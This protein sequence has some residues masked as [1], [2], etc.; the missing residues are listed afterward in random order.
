MLDK[1]FELD[2][3]YFAQIPCEL[4]AKQKRKAKKS[5][6]ENFDDHMNFG[7]IR[8]DV[9]DRFFTH[10]EQRLSKKEIHQCTKTLHNVIGF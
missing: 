9:Y 4:C 8:Q 1:C 6:T 3:E 5:A 2:S 10:I 7:R